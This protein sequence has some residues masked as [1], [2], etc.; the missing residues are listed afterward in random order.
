MTTNDSFQSA[1]LESYIIN[2]T[3]PEPSF[4]QQLFRE[5]HLKTTKPRML[6]GPI[7]GRFLTMLTQMIQPKNV[8]EIGTFT[9]YSALCIAMGLPENGKITTIDYDVEIEHLA[10]KYFAC[11]GLEHKIRF[12]V[13]DAQ[14][15]IP[16]LTESFD[17]VFLDA[18]KENNLLYYEQIM[19]KTHIGSVIIADNMLWS[20]KI[21]QTGHHDPKT[22]KIEEFNNFIQ[23]DE[24]VENVLLPLRDGIMLMRRIR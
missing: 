4:L 15:V 13:D 9:G 1:E 3:T 24:R 7:Q 21:L 5:T 23:H 10:R 14:K 12:I 19:Q 16:L 8:L 22:V 6:S 20:E 11:S 2:H 18:D 17:M